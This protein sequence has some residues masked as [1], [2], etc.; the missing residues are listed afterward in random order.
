[1]NGLEEIEQ[2]LTILKAEEKLENERK[3]KIRQLEHAKF[4]AQKKEENKQLQNQKDE[5]ERLKKK[6]HHMVDLFFKCKFCSKPVKITHGWER[7]LT[8]GKVVEVEGKCLNKKCQV[9]CEFAENKLIDSPVYFTRV[10]A[11]KTTDW[12]LAYGN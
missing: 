6:N 9:S 3:L 8:T 7:H 5:R 4:E 12:W 11:D 1:M 10:H 2:K